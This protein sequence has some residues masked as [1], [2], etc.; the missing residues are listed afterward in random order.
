MLVAIRIVG[1]ALI[2]L[3]AGNLAALFVIDLATLTSP[4]AV[5]VRYSLM[6]ISGLG[7]CLA[8]RWAIYVYLGS[9]AINWIAFFIVYDGKSLGPI[10]LSFPIPIAICALTYLAWDKL[11]PLRTHRV[12]G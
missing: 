7:F 10:W 12:E 4:T 9:F 3:G 8:R 6:I 1:V 5:A 2:L 11:K